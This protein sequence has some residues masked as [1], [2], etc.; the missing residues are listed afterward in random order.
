M[1]CSQGLLLTVLSLMMEEEESVHDDGRRMVGWDVGVGDGVAGRG[2]RDWG[3][4]RR[5][6]CG[7]GS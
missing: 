6:Q 5:D 2:M 7:H 1:E 3:R 4:R